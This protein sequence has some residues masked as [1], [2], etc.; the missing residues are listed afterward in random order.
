MEQM[1][2]L[3][4]DGVEPVSPMLE[5]G[6]YETLWADSSTTFP[7][8][9]KKFRDH[10]GALPSDF[11]DHEQALEMAGIVVEILQQST[12]AR[13]D[14][15]I[16]GTCE[17]P[18]RLRD[19]VHPLELLYF[20]GWWD[21]AYSPCIAV[22]GTRNP[23]DAGRRRA[24]RLTRAL[25][26]DGWTIVS[27]LAKGIDTEAHTTAI[28]SGGRTIGVL[29]TPLSK[30]YPRENAPLQERLAREHLVISQVPVFRYGQD[31]YRS[32]R[33]FFPQ[34]NHTMSALSE[35]TVI[36]EAGDTSGTLVQAKSAL[37]QGRKLFIL[38]SCFRDPNL[39][40]PRQLEAKGAIRVRHYDDIRCVLPSHPN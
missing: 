33:R 13:F 38:D 1:D 36:V 3:E 25:V 22:V 9:A 18:K 21:L 2:L 35:A 26:Q 12:P 34:R 14:V 7:R 15:R 16:H 17:Y 40:W 32:N 29:G 23:S 39:S 27:G 10:P 31:D 6:A 37:R 19:A 28:E 5:L 8:L 11:V 4:S 24:R 30:A 20:M